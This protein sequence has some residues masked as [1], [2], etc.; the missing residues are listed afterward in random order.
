MRELDRPAVRC[1]AVVV[2]TGVLY[3]FTTHH[4][5]RDDAPAGGA[6]PK[7]EAVPKN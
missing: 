4:Y 5:G 6:V 3:M 7:D 2:G 1:G